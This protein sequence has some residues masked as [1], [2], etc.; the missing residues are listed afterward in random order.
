M[1]QVSQLKS[2]PTEKRMVAKVKNCII[3]F[4]DER[5]DK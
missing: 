1:R 2:H 5:A 4:A 3:E